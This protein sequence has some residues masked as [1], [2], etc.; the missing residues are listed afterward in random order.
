MLYF[1]SGMDKPAEGVFS[2]LSGMDK[3]AEGVFSVLSGLDNPAA[4][5]FSDCKDMKLYRIMV[6][7]TKTFIII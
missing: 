6:R 1:L 5:G 4:V 2:V 7:F 3:H